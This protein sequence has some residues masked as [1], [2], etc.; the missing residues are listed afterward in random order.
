MF[1]SHQE[2]YNTYLCMCTCVHTCMSLSTYIFKHTCIYAA[3]I[4][5][6]AWTHTHV[7][8]HKLTA[9][10]LP[11]PLELESQWNLLTIHSTKAC[12]PGGVSTAVPFHSK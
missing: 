1:Q 11:F 4:H 3:N 7:C 12:E 6:C 8:T 9:L 5:I 2:K 10:E